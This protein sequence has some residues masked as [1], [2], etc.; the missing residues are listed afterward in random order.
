MAKADESQRM[1]LAEANSYCAQL[2]SQIMVTSIDRPDQFGPTDV[3]FRCLKPGD[4]E[5]VR[6]NIERAPDTVIKV[7]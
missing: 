5:L 2:N 3:T 6:P 4:P 7:K 1:A